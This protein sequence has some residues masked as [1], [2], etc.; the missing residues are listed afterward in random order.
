MVKKIF[1]L[2]AEDTEIEQIK[3]KAKKERQSASQFLLK[4]ALDSPN[5]ASGDW[6]DNPEDIREAIKQIA[7]KKK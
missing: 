3:Q 6:W 7:K 2:F 4:R 5:L 1:P